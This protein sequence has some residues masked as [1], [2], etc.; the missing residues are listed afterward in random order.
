MKCGHHLCIVLVRNITVIAEVGLLTNIAVITEVGLVISIAVITEV[1]L[2]TNIAVITEV[3]LL[4]NISVFTEVGGG[5][6]YKHLS[7]HLY[8]IYTYDMIIG[9]QMNSKMKHDGM[10]TI[11]S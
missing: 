3:G 8:L 4:T 5:A 10:E 6:T 7:N 1:G 2:L 9:S 11:T